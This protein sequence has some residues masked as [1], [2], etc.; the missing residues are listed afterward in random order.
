MPTFLQIW[1][2]LLDLEKSC[3]QKASYLERRSTE[4]YNEPTETS[5][6][7]PVISST[8]KEE[9][10]DYSLHLLSPFIIDYHTALQEEPIRD[11]EDNGI[12]EDTSASRTAALFL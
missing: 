2:K 3:H 6:N 4:L 7:V 9:T 12:M 8:T 11:M 1:I 10:S 5:I